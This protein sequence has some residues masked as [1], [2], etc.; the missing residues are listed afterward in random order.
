MKTVLVWILIMHSWDG[1]M[2]KVE[3][4]ATWED[5]ERMRQRVTHSAN[6]RRY[7]SAA[8]TVTGAC[9][10]VGILVPATTAPQIVVNVPPQPAPVI[11]NRVIVRKAP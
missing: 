2:V 3:N 4:I 10:Q 5:C 6:D 9:T 7:G 1:G 8:A 11:N